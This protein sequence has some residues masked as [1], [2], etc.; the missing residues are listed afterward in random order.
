MVAW[1]N[2]NLAEGLKLMYMWA[3]NEPQVQAQHEAMVGNNAVVTWYFEHQEACVSWLLTKE[4]KIGSKGQIVDIDE[5]KFRKW[6]YNCG[7]HVD[8]S[9]VS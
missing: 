5:S 2:L 3:H 9:W 8:G 6:K 4:D 1:S 7:H